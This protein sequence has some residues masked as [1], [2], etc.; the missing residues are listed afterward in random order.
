ML[1]FAILNKLLNF[2]G[3][4]YL[5]IYSLLKLFSLLF[6]NIFES[7]LQLS[8]WLQQWPGRSQLEKLPLS[9]PK[10]DSGIPVLCIDSVNITQRSYTSCQVSVKERLLFLG[11]LS[12]HIFK[13]ALGIWFHKT[14]SW[15]SW[16]AECLFDSTAF[17]KIHYS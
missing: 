7:H 16:Q 13:K 15:N 8:K 9:D 4:P 11:I 14:H 2:K 6:H 1:V 17:Q 12:D 10:I 3:L 5:G